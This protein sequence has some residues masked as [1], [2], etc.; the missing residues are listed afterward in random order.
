MAIH[1]FQFRSQK[2]LG[3]VLA[4][5][6]GDEIGN[7]RQIIAVHKGFYFFP[8][9]IVE[10]LDARSALRPIEVEYRILLSVVHG[11]KHIHKFCTKGPSPYIF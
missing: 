6:V 7:I 5:F 4:K 11:M 2:N 1:L 8:G 9:F 3:F 10:Y